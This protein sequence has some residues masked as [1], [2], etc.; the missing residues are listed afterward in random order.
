MASMLRSRT[1]TLAPRP[2]LLSKHTEN[3][4]G[5]REGR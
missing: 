3:D 4:G 2:A 5:V 1:D